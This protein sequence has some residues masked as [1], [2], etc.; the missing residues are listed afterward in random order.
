MAIC[1]AACAGESYGGHYVPTTTAYIVAQNALNNG[2]PK[3]NLAGMLVGNAWTN[4][5]WD[6]TGTLETWF[7]RN[8]ISNDT[9]NGVLATCNMST[10]GPLLHTTRGVRLD[11]M[12]E[13]HEG[14]AAVGWGGGRG[15]A[16][17]VVVSTPRGSSLP[18]CPRVRACTELTVTAGAMGWLSKRPERDVNGVLALPTLNGKSCNDYQND[19]S[20]EVRARVGLSAG[21]RGVGLPPLPPPSPCAA[22]QHGHL[23]RVLRRVQRRRQR[24]PRPLWV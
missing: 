4:A 11:A 12:T 6:N 3:I 5:F 1:V 24:E 21:G 17:V 19:A 18:T 22:R 20:T 9:R 14:E 13:V 7:W 2:Q 10:V 23:L 8:M 15:C 16:V